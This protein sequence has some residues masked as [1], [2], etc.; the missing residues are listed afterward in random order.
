M[1]G[2][3]STFTHKFPSSKARTDMQST[4]WTQNI[5]HLQNPSLALLTNQ[6]TVLE[7]QTL[8]HLNVNKPPKYMAARKIWKIGRL[9]KITFGYRYQ[10]QVL[11]TLHSNP[12]ILSLAL[13][14][15]YWIQYPIY[16]VFNSQ[17]RYWQT[18][19]QL[20]KSNLND[21][22]PLQNTLWYP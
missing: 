18:K 19:Q 2:G 15:T 22:K 5:L 13:S 8:C 14:F 10:D 7:N 12:N 16:S 21:N 20:W 3:Y 6:A 11:L 9:E 1:E 4:S 17:W